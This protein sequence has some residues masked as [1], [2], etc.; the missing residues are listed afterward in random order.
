MINI[1]RVSEKEIND[2]VFNLAHQ[3]MVYAVKVS[4]I[5]GKKNDKRF[6]FVN[7]RSG[8]IKMVD[9]MNFVIS[10]KISDLHREKI[11]NVV[12]NK[13]KLLNSKGKNRINS[14]H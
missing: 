11:L 9:N 3:G 10:E 8:E 2:D 13:I 5:N 12:N 6:C 1:Y 4:D 14:I 7:G